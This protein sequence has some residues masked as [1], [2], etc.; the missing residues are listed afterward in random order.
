MLV[1]QGLIALLF[2]AAGWSHT[3]SMTFGRTPPLIDLALLAA[4]LLG[5]A[6]ASILAV[7]AWRR[8]L[9][10]NAKVLIFL[11]FPIAVLLFGVIGAI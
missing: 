1:I 7:M 8:G 11:P 4:P 6:I 3:S 9:T 2:F 5:V 10:G